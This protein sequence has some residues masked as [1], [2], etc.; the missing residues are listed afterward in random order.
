[1]ATVMPDGKSVVGVT[2][3]GFISVLTAKVAAAAGYKTWLLCQPSEQATMMP[4]IVNEEGEDLPENLELLDTEEMDARLPETDAILIAI[5]ANIA[6]GDGMDYL[7]EK[8]G[9][10]LKR[11]VGMSR[12][13]NN[14]GMGFF[15]T[16]SRKAANADVWDN[17]EA[18]V[19]KEFD[20]RLAKTAQ[21]NGVEYTIARAGTLKGGACGDNEYTQY[22]TKK[23]YEMTKKDIISWQLLFDCN[24]RGVKLAKGDILPGP[25]FKAALTAIGTDEHDGDTGRC[26]LAEAMVRSLQYESAANIDFGVGTKLGREP[27]TDAEW[28]GMFGSL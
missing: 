15:A 9:S 28:D 14:E 26:G 8:A 27:P 18:S 11:I 4:L 21:E 7:F 24:T 10:N 16:A 17:A 6:M 22:L 3:G 12:N 25:G 13:L 2:G 5:D 1:M 20:A 23:F 19:Y